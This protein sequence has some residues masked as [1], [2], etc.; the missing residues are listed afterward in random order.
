MNNLHKR[1]ALFLLGCIPTRF[2]LV[3]L[4][5]HS[6]LQYL[7]LLGYIAL[8]PAI[9]F[10]YLFITGKRQYGSETFGEKIWWAPI[11]PVHS[12]LYFLFAYNAIRGEKN[13]WMYLLHDVVFGLTSFFVHHFVPTHLI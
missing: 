12:L 7:P 8:L 11:R 5:K 2:F 9:G 3:Y 1:Y 4:A 10:A 13:A 6:P